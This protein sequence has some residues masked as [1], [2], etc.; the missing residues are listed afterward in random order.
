MLTRICNK[1]N[2]HLLL[3]ELQNGT[4]TLEESIP[5]NSLMK[6]N[7]LLW[8]NP[9]LWYLPKEFKDY[10]HRKTCTHMYIAYLFITAKIWKQTIYSVIG[11]R[12]GW[13]VVYPDNGV[14]FSPKKVLWNHENT[15]K[16]CKFILV[17][18]RSQSEEATYYMIPTIWHSGKY[19]TMEQVKR[20][21]AVARG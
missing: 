8:Y 11:K 4:V 17:G 20:F 2:S 21:R 6:L 1:S 12:S 16:N 3:L 19:K 7:I 15:W 14:L 9:A 10:V 18:E 13:T 5:P